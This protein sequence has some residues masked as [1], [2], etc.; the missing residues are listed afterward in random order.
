MMMVV[1]VL[2]LVLVLEQVLEQVQVHVLV[3]LLDCCAAT[4]ETAGCT[5]SSLPPNR[6]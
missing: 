6:R 4:T 2:V 3:S 5:S 1:E